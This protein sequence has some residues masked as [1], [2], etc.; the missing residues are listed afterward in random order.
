MKEL[1][2]IC[3]LIICLLSGEGVGAQVININFLVTTQRP[4][5]RLS[6]L[7]EIANSGQM[8]LTLTNLTTENQ[9]FQIEAVFYSQTTSFRLITNPNVPASGG[10]L[11]PAGTVAGTKSYTVQD[12][13]E[14]F[15]EDSFI[16]GD[17]KTLVEYLASNPDGQ[18][19]SGNYKLCIRLRPETLNQQLT[20]ELSN[21][22]C[23]N[24][25]FEQLSSPLINS[26]NNQPC[27]MCTEVPPLDNPNIPFPVAFTPA[28]A[29]LNSVMVNDFSYTIYLLE[30]VTGIEDPNQLIQTAIDR[31]DVNFVVKKELLGPNVSPQLTELLQPQDF[32]KPLEK[33]RTYA[34]AVKA[35]STSISDDNLPNRGFSPAQVFKLEGVDNDS[36]TLPSECDLALAPTEAC[37]CIADSTILPKDLV[38]LGNITTLENVSVQLGYFKLVVKSATNEN[39]KFK[40]NG[41]IKNPYLNSWIQVKFDDLELKKKSSCFFAVKGKAYGVKDAGYLENGAVQQLL[42]LNQRQTGTP[43]DTITMKTGVEGAITT[44]IVSGLKEQFNVINNIDNI[45][46]TLRLNEE[47]YEATLPLGI[48]IALGDN[49]LKFGVFGMEFTPTKATMQVVIQTPPLPL[50]TPQELYFGAKDLCFS[51]NG[52]SGDQATLYLSADL[53][54][55]SFGSNYSFTLKGSE[56]LAQTTSITLDCNMAFKRIRL[57]GEIG[58]D[59]SVVRQ[60]A[61]SSQVKALFA[62][63]VEKWEELMLETSVK[64]FYFVSHPDW[65]FEI[66]EAALDLSALANPAGIR[67]PEEDQAAL[68]GNINLWTGLYAK[69]IA[70]TLPPSFKFA[71]GGQTGRGLTAGFENLTIGF[72]GSTQLTGVVENILTLEG[73]SGGVLSGWQFSIDRLALTIKSA[74]HDLSFIP[75]LEGRLRFPLFDDPF[76]YTAEYRQSDKS[77]VLAVIGD[78]VELKA[79]SIKSVFKMQEGSRVECI[80]T[81]ARPTSSAVYDAEIKISLN[82][83]WSII[84]TTKGIDIPL[85]QFTGLRYSTKTGFES[86]PTLGFVTTSTTGAGN[87][88]PAIPHVKGFDADLKNITPF[89]DGKFEEG[90]GVRLGVSFTLGIKLI[91]QN[92]SASQSNDTWSSFGA[93]ATLELSAV[94]KI[95]ED[96]KPSIEEFNLNLLG[97][98]IDADAAVCHIKGSFTLIDNDPVFGNGFRGCVDFKLGVGVEVQGNVAAIFGRTMGT[99]SY[100]YF[101]IDG[102]IENL[103]LMIGQYL[104]INGFVGG[105]SYNMKMRENSPKPMID[106]VV[107]RL[108]GG[109]QCSTDAPMSNFPQVPEEGKFQL[110]FSVLFKDAAAGGFAFNG[111]MGLFSQIDLERGGVD[112]LAVGGFMDFIKPPTASLAIGVNN[113]MKLR[114]SL[115][116]MYDFNNHVLTGSS[117]VYINVGNVLVGTARTDN[118]DLNEPDLAGKMALYVGSNDWYV[119]IGNPWAPTNAGD[120]GNLLA[121][122]PQ[123]AEVSVVIP[124]FNIRLGGAGAYFAMGTYGIYGL[125]PLPPNREGF[126]I[127]D[128]IRSQLMS[129]RGAPDP[130]LTSGAGIAFGGWMGFDYATPWLFDALRAGINLGA[131]FDVALLRYAASASCDGASGMLG[132][133]GFYGRG[134][135]YAYIKGALQWKHDDDNIEDLYKIDSQM[136]ADFGGPNPT[137]LKG[138]LEFLNSNL[139]DLA[140]GLNPVVGAAVWWALDTEDEDGNP[141]KTYVPIEIGT[142]CI[143]SS[144]PVVDRSQGTESIVSR[145]TPGDSIEPQGSI[146]VSLSKQLEQ[147]W[148]WYDAGTKT[149]YKRRWKL[150]SYELK[151][152]NS[153]VIPLLMTDRRESK[154]LVF[155]INGNNTTQ[156]PATGETISFMMVLVL[157]E[158]KQNTN[159]WVETEFKTTSTVALKVKPNDYQ[160]AFS[161]IVLSYPAIGQQFYLPNEGLE[162]ERFVLLNYN[163]QNE[164]N[165][166]EQNRVGYSKRKYVRVKQGETVVGEVP[167]EVKMMPNGI[168]ALA[169]KLPALTTNSLYSVEF[170][171]EVTPPVSFQANSSYQQLSSNTLSGNSTNT[172]QAVKKKI[173]SYSFKTSQFATF[174]EKINRIPSQSKRFV[175]ESNTN[176]LV[177]KLPLRE[178]GWDNFELNSSTTPLVNRSVERLYSYLKAIPVFNAPWHE[179][180]KK[181]LNDWELQLI[182]LRNQLAAS[183]SPAPA[184]ESVMQKRD[185]LATEAQRVADE[186][187]LRGFTDENI[188][189]KNQLKAILEGTLEVAVE[190]NANQ[191]QIELEDDWDQKIME[192][193]R[194]VGIEFAMPT[195][196]GYNFKLQYRYPT[197]QPSQIGGNSIL[198]YNK[199]N[200]PTNTLMTIMYA[201]FDKGFMDLQSNSAT[202]MQQVQTARNIESRFNR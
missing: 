27:P 3:W 50:Q 124:G 162:D 29:Q 83:K 44:G 184:G 140:W 194:Q 181:N 155:T 84:D 18:I 2:K 105:L 58:L 47:S 111:G 89:F 13:R 19:P 119:Y 72:N 15:G 192:V 70:V 113:G 31:N 193:G 98:G 12:L 165:S 125:P 91:G 66:K 10:V 149:A 100:S 68:A 37:A 175:Q 57:V 63:E 147:K 185:R 117:R 20:N 135:L 163:I 123:Y 96:Y 60:V 172:Q 138:E 36:R 168:S 183:A 127:P 158:S 93:S 45:E 16:T 69:R 145:I 115:G 56:D 118:A 157:E 174:S 180:V 142:P 92:G 28:L 198:L 134:Q 94:C 173:L 30:M 136:M 137:W 182:A 95:G 112:Y 154:E 148:Q 85:M 61:D 177:S 32:S 121:S 133:N 179:Q 186:L 46:R 161:D 139:I 104:A 152:A 51:P 52:I 9:P 200:A 102:K 42:A 75:K 153:T 24:L 143:P 38:D 144:G 167:F 191:Q 41:L 159:N 199:S 48:D 146:Y 132:V 34:L 39:G 5:S 151:K 80:F 107:D 8:I 86:Q 26:I 156:K 110:L 170:W 195:A 187:A 59:T 120:P 71:K 21:E 188:A 128:N 55:P 114:A 77:L 189:A 169:Y 62:V 116:L 78:N 106:A 103:N 99:N 22:G 164:V 11:G 90:G 126:S 166:F 43:A 129:T 79:K 54:L 122:M 141:A 190:C 109:G 6:E 108:I 33:G 7:E 67:L 131:G 101:S 196:G 82:G 88:P 202:A 49:K 97:I 87:Q 25:T 81:K 74:N 130:S 23:A 176:V 178:E 150:K 17:G 65:A 197:L 64:P 53:R 76:R 35:K 73:D 4:L 1:R 171:L 201:G 14:L 160:I 40:G